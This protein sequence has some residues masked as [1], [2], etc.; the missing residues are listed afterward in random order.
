MLTRHCAASF[1]AAFALFLSACDS[2]APHAQKSAPASAPLFRADVP[3]STDPR[4]GSG[5]AGGSGCVP[6]TAPL[7]DGVWFG[8][9]VAWDASGVVFDPACFYGNEAAFAKAAERGD[10]PPPNGFYIVNDD[11]AT[12]RIEVARGADAR[13]NYPGAKLTDYAGLR[14]N[15]GAY[16]TCPGEWCAFWLF[17]NGGRVTNLRPQYL[18]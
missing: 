2:G 8:F 3:R 14:A 4:P 10:E 17:V 15:P 12:R 11:K 5:G 1:V 9:I 18:P 6:A 16:Q 13:T 7:P